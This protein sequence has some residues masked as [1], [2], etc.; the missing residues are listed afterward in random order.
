MSESKNDEVKVG[1]DFM[2][3]S[4]TFKMGEKEFKLGILVVKF[5]SEKVEVY[6]LGNALRSIIDRGERLLP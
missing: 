4:K 2:S 1:L 3:F 5:P 6:H